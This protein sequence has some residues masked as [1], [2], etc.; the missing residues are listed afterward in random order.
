[1]TLTFLNFYIK[2]V[3]RRYDDNGYGYGAGGGNYDRDGTSGVAVIF[4]G[5]G[6]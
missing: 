2:F 3:I 4:T 5:S 6:V 1:M